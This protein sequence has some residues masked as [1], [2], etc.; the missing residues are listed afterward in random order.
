[1]QEDLQNENIP[2]DPTTPT[3]EHDTVASQ[4]SS[5]EPTSQRAT[6]SVEASTTSSTEPATSRTPAAT[7]SSYR[8][9]IAERLARSAQQ[10]GGGSPAAQ[11]RPMAHASDVEQ[12]TGRTF[13]SE[14]EKS[15]IPASIEQSTKSREV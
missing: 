13:G 14:P 9:I 6:E 3:S 5:P 12:P 11:S 10:R 15:A 8:D 2:F 4:D 1:M 7:A